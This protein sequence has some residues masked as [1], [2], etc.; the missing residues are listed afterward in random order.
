MGGVNTHFTTYIIRTN[1][2]ASGLSVC[3]IPAVPAELVP[4]CAA[5]GEL[6]SPGVTCTALGCVTFGTAARPGGEITAMG[7]SEKPAK[8]PLK[9]KLHVIARISTSLTQVFSP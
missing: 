6:W 9:I 1:P 3:W 5:P 2:A 7:V 8:P 4:G